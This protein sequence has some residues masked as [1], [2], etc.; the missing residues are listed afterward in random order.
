LCTAYKSL[1]S[2]DKAANRVVEKRKN[3]YTV[4]KIQNSLTNGDVCIAQPHRSYVFEE[5]VQLVVGKSHKERTLYL[6]N[7]ILLIAIAKPKKKK[8]D[9][10]AILPLEKMTVDDCD[11]ERQIF[12]ITVDDGSEY[13]FES[14][15]KASWIQLLNS[16]IKKLHVLPPEVSDL[17]VEAEEHAEA[18]KD[19]F[20]KGDLLENG[21]LL[22]TKRSL[23]KKILK[24]S[25]IDN[26]E[27]VMREVKKLAR[28]I[29]KYEQIKDEHQQHWEDYKKTQD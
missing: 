17:R 1:R 11:T 9:V 27:A 7:D 13:V 12:K 2:M 5:E 20:F 4:L 26:P 3:L 6:F 23:M 8:Y 18:Q 22:V 14:D 21:E 24:W 28:R 25:E 29:E 10:D 15:S 19:N 16:T